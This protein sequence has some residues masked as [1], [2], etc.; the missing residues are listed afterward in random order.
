LFVVFKSKDM[1]KTLLI[2]MLAFL[3]GYEASTAYAY[4]AVEAKKEK[5][6][7]KQKVKKVKPIKVTVPTLNDSAD[8][9]AYVFGTWQSN[10]LKTYMMQ[11]GVDTIYINDFGKGILD[12]VNI[13]PADKQKH[14]Y[15][16]GQQIGEQIEQMARQVSQEYYAAEQGRTLDKRIIAAAI[17]KGLFGQNEITPDSAGV[18]FQE[19]MTLRQEQNMEAMYGENRVLGEQWLAENKKK[20]GVITL[21]SGLQYKVLVEG[22]GPVPTP[23]QTVEVHYEGHLIDGTEF[24]SSYKRNQPSTF[25]CNQVIKGWTEAL[26]KMPVGSKWELYIPYDLAYGDRNTG[27]IK[28]YSTLIFTVELLGIKE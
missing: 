4:S 2:T 22:D 28:P 1:K 15:M 13:D 27:Q 14:A 18:A 5:K 7:K 10:G 26:S 16:Q 25:R 11:L 12:R 19:A 6:E 24:D 3:F 9:L 17:V 20:D 21:P 8:S 23:E